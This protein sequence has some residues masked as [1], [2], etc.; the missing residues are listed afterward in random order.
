MGIYFG[1]IS[2]TLTGVCAML[3]ASPLLRGAFANLDKRAMRIGIA[4]GG[5]VAFAVVALILYRTLGR[6]D[7]LGP[8][9]AA[10]A[11]AAHPGVSASASGAPPDSMENVVARLEAR[12]ARD[13]GKREDWLLLA[14]S[15]EFMG[16]DADAQRA[17]AHA[18]SPADAPPPS[19][20]AGAAAPVAASYT[21]PRTS[22]SASAASDSVAEYERRAHARP[23]D[24]DAWRAL[25][26]LYRRQ[27]ESAKAR[28]AFAK[29][30]RLNAM[31]ADTWANYADVLASASGGSLRQSA[32]AIDAALKMNPAHPKALWLKASLAYEE[33]RYADAL[34]VWKQ[35]RAVLPPDSSDGR[36]IDANIAEASELAGVPGATGTTTPAVAASSAPAAATVTGTVSIGSKFAGRVPAGATL[37]IYAKAV[38][39]PGPPLAVI[40]QV[41]SSWPVRF[42]LDDTLAMIPSRKLSQ[43]DRVVIEARISRS[44]QATPA[45]GDLYVTSAVLNPAERKK[46]ALVIDREVS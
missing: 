27:R 45:A 1:F 17:R 28:D 14:Q 19:A 35:L 21:A 23:D 34:A 22:S 15:Y 44:G 42:Q 29:L 46:L 32:Q 37:F 36:V 10:A 33:H 16:R 18:D 43:F 25:A 7:L 24:A 5:V 41:A 4:A 26:E 3:I 39:S 40:R 20:S 11:P 9:V 12:I 13:G 8:H 2:G 30:V 6:P 31:N 38:D